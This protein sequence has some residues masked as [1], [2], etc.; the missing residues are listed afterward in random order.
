MKRHTPFATAAALWIAASSA[1]AED[2]PAELTKPVDPA[3]AAARSFGFAALP[4]Q[5]DERTADNAAMAQDAVYSLTWKDKYGDPPAEH[6]ASLYEIYCM[7]G[8]YNVSNLYVLKDEE[9]KLS[10][11]SFAQPTFDVVYVDG[12]DSE[13]KLK[14]DPTVTGYSATFLLTN[15]FFDEKTQTL[16]E[17][18]KWRGL[19]DAWSVGD[20]QLRDGQFVLTRYEIDPIYEANLD[21]PPQKLEDK[22][23]QL[24]PSV[25]KK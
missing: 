3:I 1:F 14:R 23:F 2:K 12:D 11:V 22:S 19:G 5:C 20:W 21:N 24:F 9:N 16:T 10:L 7:S 15:S 18:A 6:K 4:G 13:T 8:A 25:K 17:F